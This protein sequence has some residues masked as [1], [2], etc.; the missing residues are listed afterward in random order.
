MFLC[1]LFKKKDVKKCLCV[2]Q[3]QQGSRPGPASGGISNHLNFINDSHLI[4]SNTTSHHQHTE[5]ISNWN[6]SRG[7]TFLNTYAKNAYLVTEHVS[8]CS[9]IKFLGTL[10]INRHEC[11]CS[12]Y[13]QGVVTLHISMVQA[14]WPAARPS[15]SMKILS[16]PVTKSHA[17]PCKQPQTRDIFTLQHFPFMLKHI[18]QST[19][20][21]L[22]SARGGGHLSFEANNDIW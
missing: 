20:A 21:P 7:N 1:K 19:T 12:P 6:H 4:Y 2:S 22:E 11:T 10:H 8:W 15:G 17:T 18:T 13:I 9:L 14:T 16:S 3:T 5:T